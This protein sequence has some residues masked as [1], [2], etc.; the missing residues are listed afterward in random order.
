MKNAAGVRAAVSAK[1]PVADSVDGGSAA[2]VDV[3]TTALDEAGMAWLRY[4][5][6]F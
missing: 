3:F 5:A 6:G 2:L 4:A 1:A